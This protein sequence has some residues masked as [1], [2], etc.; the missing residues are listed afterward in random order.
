VLGNFKIG[1][2]ELFICLGLAS[3]CNPLDL[4]LL[5]ARITDM[6]HQHPTRFSVLERELKAI[7]GKKS[8]A[9]GITI[10]D[11]KLYTKP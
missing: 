1:S 4:C 2:H 7:L 10:P 11:L 5:M 8:N 9:G 6:S 3:N